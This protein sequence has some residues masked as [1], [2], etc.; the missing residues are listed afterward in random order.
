MNNIITKEDL[1]NQIMD[2]LWEKYGCEFYDS[3][4]IQL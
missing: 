1:K 4:K 2:F 3:T